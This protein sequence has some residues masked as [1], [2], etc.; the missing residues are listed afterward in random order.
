MPKKYYAVKKGREP[1]I[2]DN[3]DK[4]KSQVQGFSGALYKGFDTLEEAES[5]MGSA[6]GKEQSVSELP[7]CYAFVDGSFNVRTSTYGYGGFI[8]HKGE[9]K[10]K[11]Q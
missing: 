9:N 1:G 3:W 8:V 2:F 7:D 10:R 5:Y 4:C 6:P 11:R